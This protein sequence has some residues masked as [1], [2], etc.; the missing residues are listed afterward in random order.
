MGHRIRQRR[1]VARSAGSC[2]WKLRLEVRALIE[3][4]LCNM[5]VLLGNNL[6]EALRRFI[7]RIY[8]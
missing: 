8:E 1:Q 2:F 7:V 5:V 6:L 3:L 4:I